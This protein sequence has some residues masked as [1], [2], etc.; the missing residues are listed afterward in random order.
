VK[1][2]SR[3]RETSE[4]GVYVLVGVLS[5]ATL[6]LVGFILKNTDHVQVD[7]VLFSATASLIWVILI[8]LVLGI[9]GGLALSVLARRARDAPPGDDHAPVL[10]P[11]DHLA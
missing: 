6:Y 3:L 5:V 7:F 8:S 1:L 10:D 2:G 11:P 4:Q 9:A